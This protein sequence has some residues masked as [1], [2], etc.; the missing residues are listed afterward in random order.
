MCRVAPTALFKWCIVLL[1]AAMSAVPHSIATSGNSQSCR[2]NVA[3]LSGVPCRIGFGFGAVLL[4]VLL[5]LAVVH[6]VR[7]GDNAS[8]GIS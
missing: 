6:A 5:G 7:H 3:A 8:T 4:L 1:L 2:S